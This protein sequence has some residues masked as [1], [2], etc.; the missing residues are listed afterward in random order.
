MFPRKGPEMVVVWDLKWPEDVFL[1]AVPLKGFWRHIRVHTCVTESSG[2]WLMSSLRDHEFPPPT[3][4]RLVTTIFSVTSG[5]R[6]QGLLGR[7][8]CL[9]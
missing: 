7:E 8:A 4:N 3:K 5:V 9:V 2:V 6:V 1:A